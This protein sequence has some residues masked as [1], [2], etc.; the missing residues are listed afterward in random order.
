MIS[1]FSYAFN[2]I[3]P[4]LALVLMGYILKSRKIFSEDFFKKINFF[5]FHYSFPFLMF[6]N[7]YSVESIRK[8]D[9]RMALFLVC[10]AGILMILG[11]GIANVVTNVRNRKGVI[12]QAGFRSNFALIGLPLSE[13]LAGNEGLILTSSMQAPIVIMYNFFSVLF[14]VIY[15]D[16]A[17][18]SVRKI[19]RNIVRNP[20]IQGLSAGIAALLIREILPLSADGSLVFTLSGNLPWVYKVI[21][22][23]GRLATPLALISL[24]GQF[25]FSQTGGMK[26]EVI[27]SVFMRLIL[28][29]VIGLSLA[30]AA[31]RAGFIALTPAAV[32]TMI[33]CFGS[34]LAVSSVPMASEMKADAALAGQI[35]VWTSILSMF[36]IFAMTVLFRTAGLL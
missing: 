27:T 29:P 36:T 34:P 12:I 26:K 15:S 2:A 3:A 8:L 24:G 20:L 31:E 23:L 14:L 11:I 30:F 32:S 16:D 35:V 19:L 10:A 21:A 1:V 4:V 5:A 6:D 17:K 33:A 28:A 25:T 13:G 9:F 18:F 7:L 22:Y